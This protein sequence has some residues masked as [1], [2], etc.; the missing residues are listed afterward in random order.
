MNRLSRFLGSSWADGS[1][2]AQVG[3]G[4]SVAGPG[5]AT[6]GGEHSAGNEV[7]LL[8]KKYFDTGSECAQNVQMTY[9]RDGVVR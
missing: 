7:S 6:L 8:I 5:M 9:W 3:P 2:S 1:S 4:L